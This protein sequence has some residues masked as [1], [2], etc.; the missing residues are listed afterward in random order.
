MTDN[1][2][3]KCHKQSNSWG[4][5]CWEKEYQ[6]ENCQ[7]FQI[8]TN[9]RKEKKWFRKVSVEREYSH[10]KKWFKENHNKEHRCTSNEFSV[11]DRSSWDRLGEEE[12]DSSSF[13]LSSDHSSAQEKDD[14]KSSNLDKWESKIR[15]YPLCLSKR[16]SIKYQWWQKQDH[17]KKNNKWYKLISYYFTKCVECDIEHSGEFMIYGD[18]KQYI[19]GF[20]QNFNY[21]RL[22]HFELLHTRLRNATKMY[23]F[24]SFGW[25]ELIMTVWHFI[26]Y[27]KCADTCASSCFFKCFGNLLGCDENCGIVWFWDITKMIL[28]TLRNNESMSWLLWEYI[29]K[30][31]DIF[32]FVDLERWYLS[33]DNARKKSR[34]IMEVYRILFT[35]RITLW[36]VVLVARVSLSFWASHLKL[37]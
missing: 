10:D 27:E 28:F 23:I 36:T 19:G 30:C 13:Y 25:N 21:F 1:I 2:T 35:N 5:K 26:S 14:K 24:Y 3:C 18:D 17:S 11:D 9:D 16:K 7:K 4:N 31:I 34:H 8:N 32:V 37:W 20:L 33:C 6:S 12:I 15:Q 22:H 29:E